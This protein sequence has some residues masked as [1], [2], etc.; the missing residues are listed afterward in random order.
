ME[1]ELE[2]AIRED[3]RE[4]VISWL[5]NWRWQAGQVRGFLTTLS[6]VE[7][8]ASGDDEV[9]LTALQTSVATAAQAKALLIEDSEDSLPAIT[10][11]AR[12]SIAEVTNELG[13]LAAV[14][15]IHIGE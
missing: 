1:E 6:Q 10:K 5:T 8:N 15:G 3:S 12:E 9:F 4:L 14:H 13:M 11:S 7:G 2:K